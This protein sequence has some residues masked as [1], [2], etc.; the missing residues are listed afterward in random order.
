MFISSKE[1]VLL[2]VEVE[3]EQDVELVAAVNNADPSN[4]APSLLTVDTSEHGGGGRSFFL[5]IGGSSIA[6]DSESESE[7]KYLLFLIHLK[8]VL[9]QKID[10]FKELTPRSRTYEL[11]GQ[12]KK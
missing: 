5:P 1:L 10:I 2:G 12:G 7:D 11:R 6:P 3:Q 8:G 4:V 9:V